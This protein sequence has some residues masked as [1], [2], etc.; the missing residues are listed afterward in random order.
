LPV[1]AFTSPPRPSK[2][3]AISWAEWEGVPLKSMCSMKCEM[4]AWCSGSN[5]EPTPIQT[6]RA[7]E[8]TPARGS[9]TTRSPEAVVLSVCSTL[10]AG[11]PAVEA[12]RLR[13]RR[14][15]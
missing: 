14:P 1:A 3:S 4:P 10:T 7:S 6:P 8:R 15:A 9:V 12:R 11:R 5:R 13:R 2:T